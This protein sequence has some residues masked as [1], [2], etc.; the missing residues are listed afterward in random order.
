MKSSFFRL[1]YFSGRN[2]GFPSRVEN[3]IVCAA[4]DEDILKGANHLVGPDSGDWRCERVGPLLTDSSLLN[5]DGREINWR[6]L[7]NLVQNAGKRV[8]NGACC[9]CLF[10]DCRQIVT[11]DKLSTSAVGPS[12]CCN[13]PVTFLDEVLET[14]YLASPY[15]HSKNIPMAPVFLIKENCFRNALV[16]F[17]TGVKMSE[18]KEICLFKCD[19]MLSLGGSRQ[20]G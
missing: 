8:E 19:R 6:D 15:D 1:A 12:E 3:V 13:L 11:L 2:Q 14:V 16:R 7:F 10:T 20:G 4:T 18:F 17:L 9:L 5:Q